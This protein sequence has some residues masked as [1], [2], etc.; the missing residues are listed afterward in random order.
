[1][2]RRRSW[3]RKR[4]VSN[5]RWKCWIFGWAITIGLILGTSS[6]YPASRLIFPRFSF[7]TGTITGIALANP[8]T[9]DAAV[10][11]V[12]RGV[13][14]KPLTG[15]GFSSQKTWTVRRGQQS[16]KL[17]NE[18]FGAALPADK[19]GWIEATSPVDGITGFFLFLNLKGTE[20]DGADPPV[21]APEVVFNQVE[22]GPQT[23]TELNLVN[24][25]DSTAQVTLRLNG[26]GIPP[27]TKSVTIAAKGMVRLDAGQFFGVGQIPGSSYVRVLA[28]VPVA[29]FEFVKDSQGDLIGLNAQH[30]RQRLSEIYF[31]QMAVRGPWK[32]EIGLVNYSAAPVILTLTAY[33]ADGSQFGSE[34]LQN[35][36]VNY[37]LDKGAS[38]RE[39][40]AALFGFKGQNPLDGWIKV[41]ATSPSVNGYIRYGLP[42]T[43]SVALVAAPAE[44]VTRALFSHI[45]TIE[46]FFTGLAVLNAGS[47][48]ANVR[49]MAFTPDGKSLGSYDTVVAPGHRISKL[50]NELIPKAAGQGGGFI[51]VKSDVPVFAT[52]LFGSGKILA[53]IPP[54]V[55]PQQFVPEGGA[56]AGL[57]IS[58]P[59]ALLQPASG[60]KFQVSGASGSVTWK[61]N[62][63]AGG[64]DTV[65]RI[66]NGIY[67]APSK[68]PDPQSV[69][70]SAENS[71]RAAGA[72]VDLVRK[73]E[74]FS[75][76][77][78]VQAVAYLTSLKRL[79][80][81]E[82]S[83]ISTGDESGS[84]I[85]PTAAQ[86]SIY[87]LI[88]TGGRAP[89]ITLDNE[90]IAD[91]VP[92]TASGGKEYMLLAAR[93]S[94]RILRLDPAQPQNPYEVARGLSQPSSM[95]VD[96]VSGNL[97]VAEAD[98]ISTVPRQSLE[99]GLRSQS[100]SLKKHFPTPGP[101]RASSLVQA[102]ASSLAVDECTGNVYFTDREAG[103]VNVYSKATGQT[104]VAAVNFTDPTAILAIY[105][106]GI[107]CPAALNL[108]VVERNA[109]DPEQGWVTQVLP[110]SGQQYI[111]FNV[112][113]AFEVTFL[114]DDN[115]YTEVAGILFGQIV[116][117]VADLYF[118]DL[119]DDYTLHP[120]NGL[121]DSLC[122]GSVFLGDPDL[123][124]VIREGL[125]MG[126][127][128]VIT[129]DRA[130]G[131]T[132]IDAP[133]REVLF[134]DGIEF[135]PLLQDVRL[136]DNYIFDLEPLQS[137]SLIHTLDLSD[138]LL[139]PPAG[140]RR[141]RRLF[142]II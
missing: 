89:V 97:L 80:E 127:G 43:G 22:A 67:T 98:R 12:V 6:L 76:L 132:S 45:A 48:V 117:Q 28:N 55:V 37:S 96:R 54:Q 18:W 104:S 59:A 141:L 113:S 56:V 122:V 64:N 11:L 42:S 121:I 87:E 130:Q 92:F 21:S 15:S 27:I 65:G 71:G 2:V 110:Y 86:S 138:N 137:L 128:G 4:I 36:P 9:Q 119:P 72:S 123:E 120:T 24:T 51:W 63:I 44:G 135:F 77:G 88:P 26:P 93:T 106:E 142:Q 73:E 7:D 108:L 140:I 90:E 103:T 81:A 131:L 114:P 109:L 46:G 29:G 91:M 112:P 52:S 66:K 3:F 111:W 32:T 94:G 102:T 68:P 20:F 25:S 95:V 34:S 30:E 16:A 57:A 13:D 23:S 139:F 133:T 115:P 49:V 60:Q 1:M 31:P 61:V 99:A 5:N 19:I 126:P 118:A 40:V 39:D 107:S 10:T 41:Q 101:V 50:I 47:V 129:C 74:L 14:G 125:G 58:P 83:G 79:Y 53:N 100:Q 105:R 82:L 38:M 136:E 78:L 134:L 116:D 124:S 35:N 17:L 75:G 8:T 84:G 70:I 62:G 69:T 33:K 85:E